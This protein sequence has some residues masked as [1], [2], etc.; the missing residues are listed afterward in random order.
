MLTI[1][2][3][4]L[5]DQRRT[6]PAWAS[7]VVVSIVL[8]SAMWPSMRA[9]ASLDSYLA[10]L[11]EA[12]TDLFAIDQMSTGTG[13]LNAELYSLMLPLLFI[14]FGIT[15]GARMVAGE[16]EAGTLDLLLVSPLSTTRLL[17]GEALAL[18]VA[19]LTLGSAAA[20]GTAAGSVLFGLGVAPV[21][22]LA[23]ATACV[24]LGLVH[25]IVALAVGALL[26]RRGLATGAATA[27]ALA[28][29]VLYVG[30][31]FVD[32]L[33]AVRVLSPFHMALHA[34]PLADSFPATFLALPVV[35]AA[36][37]LLTLPLWARRDIGVHR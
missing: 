28:A 23:G 17:L 36:L 16:E 4:A 26:G 25:G 24:L 30:G 31:M 13:F 22:A 21:S 35:S 11:P 32:D 2:R 10:E 15:R 27:A 18:T 20:L 7:A 8:E 12:L 1:C 37:V 3:K 33:S 29:Y 6:L 5:W 14:V 34:G 19:M 9:M